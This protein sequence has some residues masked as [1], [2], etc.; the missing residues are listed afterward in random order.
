MECRLCGT[1]FDDSLDICPGCNVNAETLKAKVQVPPPIGAVSDY[2][3]L[4]SES[5]SGEL[6]SMLNSFFR[7]TDV[8]VVIVIVNSTLPL[9]PAEYAFLLYNQWGVGKRGVNRGLLILLSLT[10]RHLETEVGLG[11]ESILPEEVGDRIVQE[12]F[13]PNFRE[14]NFFEGLRAGTRAVLDAL[15]EKLP[16]LH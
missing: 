14:G 8:P 7:Q 2:P 5:Q 6:S 1:E 13:V 3:N 11:L 15:L 4:L 16:T 9:T 12:A 10:Q